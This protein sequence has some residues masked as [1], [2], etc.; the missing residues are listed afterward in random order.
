MRKTGAVLC[1]ALILIS[2]AGQRE[3]ASFPEKFEGLTQMVLATETKTMSFTDTTVGK[4]LGFKLGS[5][6]VRVTSSVTYDFYLD[7]DNDTYAMSFNQET[8]TLTFEAPPLRVKKPVISGTQVSYPETNFL[9]NSQEK[10][11]KRLESLTEEFTPEGERLVKEQ[12]V[13]DKCTEMLKKYLMDLCAKLGFQVK[14]IVVTYRAPQ[15]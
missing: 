5:A 3:I 15:A 1:G 8:Q 13:I 4:I 12:Y 6:Q 2:C 10:A 11:V 14:E 7:F 9:I